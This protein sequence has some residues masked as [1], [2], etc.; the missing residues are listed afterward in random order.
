MSYN[1]R[2]ITLIITRHTVR[3]SCA[4]NEQQY[5]YAS[6]AKNLLVHALIIYRRKKSRLG[7]LVAWE[8]VSPYNAYN[9][10][11]YLGI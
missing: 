4:R 8:Y 1:S 7:L 10:K 9:A 3:I 6:I 11:N 5:A 2:D